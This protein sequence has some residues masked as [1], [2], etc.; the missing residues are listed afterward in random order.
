[1]IAGTGALAFHPVTPDRW[2]DFE[3]LFGDRGACGGC[4]C[5]WL[6]LKRSEYDA[7]KGA[8]NRR[9][10]Q[11]IVDSGEIPGLLAYDGDQPVGWCAVGLREVYPLLQRS[12]TLK[13]V[14]D[15]PV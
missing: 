7:Q 12:R 14:D 4:W 9:A 11:A 13:P 15:Q 10:M 6:R 8:G 2:Q 1:M 3:Q 5:M